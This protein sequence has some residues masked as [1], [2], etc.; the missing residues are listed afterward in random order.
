M[1][2]WSVCCQQAIAASRASGPLAPSSAH[3]VGCTGDAHERRADRRRRPRRSRLV[4]GVVVG[5]VPQPSRPPLAVGRTAPPSATTGGMPPASRIATRLAALS[6]AGLE[7]ATR[8]AWPPAA[9]FVAARR[10]R[11]AAGLRAA[12]L[13]ALSW[14]SLENAHAACFWPPA[15]RSSRRDERRDRRPHG[16]RPGWR[17][18][19]NRSSKPIGLL[20]AA[21]RFLL[22]SAT[23]GGMPPALPI[24]VRLAALTRRGS[25]TP[26]RPLSSQMPSRSSRAPL[27]VR[28]PFA[29][30]WA[31]E[32]RCYGATCWVT[33]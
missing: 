31:S 6:W 29:T 11:D 26:S 9:A 7:N 14:A 23:S 20:L 4:G 30:C 1:L 12:W 28:Y 10:R 18:C 24:A 5:E 16:S 15:A 19:C 21:G 25:S 27:A 17:R 33:T 2:G 3:R 22:T 8:L 32:C 13:A